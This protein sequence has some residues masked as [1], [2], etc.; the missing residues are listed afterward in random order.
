MSGSSYGT[1][2][3]VSRIGGR[4]GECGSKP[5]TLSRKSTKVPHLTALLGPLRGS[6][7]VEQAAAADLAVFGKQPVVAE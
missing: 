2:A 4:T 3:C 7:F 1:A 6:A 5:S